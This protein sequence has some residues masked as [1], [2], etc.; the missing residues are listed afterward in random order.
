MTERTNNG[1]DEPA[2][3]KPTHAEP[4][5][6]EPTE[7]EPTEEAA[8]PVEEPTAE[9]EAPA[10][11]SDSVERFR[12][13]H[14]VPS[15]GHSWGRWLAAAALIVALCGL[16]LALWMSYLSAWADFHTT[17]PT[18]ATT[19]TSPTAPGPNP[20]QVTDAKN[21][22]CGAYTMVH[23]AVQ[24]W[25]AT[26]PGNDQGTIVAVAANTR[27]A[28]SFGSTYLISQTD[29]ATPAP[30]ASAVRAYADNLAEVT[31][32]SLAGVHGDDPAQ[33]KRIQDWGPL[34][35]QITDLCK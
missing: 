15:D 18:A 9:S 11:E 8:E 6:V 4:T 23:N 35:D 12:T 7:A 26:N 28:A 2:A 16:G 3:A 13:R 34:N 25:V 22:T 17:S 5:H 31:M 19:T 29:P 1:P 33:A 21:Q 27:L 10:A 30:L 24:Q 32:N 20:Q 14:S